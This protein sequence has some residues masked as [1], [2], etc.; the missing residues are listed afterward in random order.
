MAADR[1]TKTHGG[2]SSASG[3]AVAGSPE[4]EE[5]PAEVHVRKRPRH[6]GPA[7]VPPSHASSSHDGGSSSDSDPREL[8]SGS[9][10]G[11]TAEDL[12]AGA[13][14]PQYPAEAPAP[15]AGS[16]DALGLLSALGLGVPRPRAPFSTL[17]DRIVRSLSRS[18]E[19][20]RNIIFSFPAIALGVP[21]DVLAR[22]AQPNG[23]IP[24]E[25][26]QPARP[27]SLT[28]TSRGMDA[29]VEGMFEA[30][31]MLALARSPVPNMRIVYKPPVAFDLT[32]ERTLE[33][34]VAYAN[35]AWMYMFMLPK[36]I[37]DK[38]RPVGSNVL[39]RHI[40]AAALRLAAIVGAATPATVLTGAPALSMPML[41]RMSDEELL[42][43]Y[44]DGVLL[45]GSAVR[46]RGHVVRAFRQAYFRAVAQSLILRRSY[47]RVRTRLQ[48]ECILQN[49]VLDAARAGAFSLTLL[50]PAAAGVVAAHPLV[51]EMFAGLAFASNWDVDVDEVVQ[52][53]YNP[54]GVV[55]SISVIYQNAELVSNG[56]RGFITAADPALDM[57]SLTH[58]YS[59]AAP[60]REVM[61]LP[62]YDAPSH[63]MVLSGL[64]SLGPI[65]SAVSNVAS[66]SLVDAYMAALGQAGAAGA[67]SSSSSGSSSVDARALAAGAISP[68][69]M[70]SV[71]GGEHKV[72]LSLPPPGQL[73]LSLPRLI[74]GLMGD[75]EDDDD[76]VADVDAMFGAHRASPI[77][78]GVM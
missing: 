75:D 53:S 18:C 29:S 74:S 50:N 77:V 36:F 6:A 62:V 59:S 65:S 9:S 26:L 35:R 66:A 8:T 56:T 33:L 68:W 10:R 39:A 78:Q 28:L 48:L 21:Y 34:R 72:D 42:H 76:I 69:S 16:D 20:D 22:M 71:T 40:A 13:A 47:Q 32:C 67:S 61:G 43:A 58:S 44:D 27:T 2:I 38:Y 15:H 4:L 49:E 41:E 14:M 7:A 73:G 54:M 31:M 12:F 70:N 25:L 57:D 17:E 52:I 60:M 51:Q 46:P 45:G 63:N 55:S 37:P 1:R 19:A 11:E 64:H 24:V 5:P 30:T 3:S 23:S